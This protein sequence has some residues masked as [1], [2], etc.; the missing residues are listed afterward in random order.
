MIGRL[1]SLSEHQFDI[2]IIGCGPAALSAAVN[3]KNKNRDIVVLGSELCSPPMH[4]APMINNYLGFPSITGEELRQSFLGHA[5]LMGVNIIKSKAENVFPDENGY[6]VMSGEEMLRAKTVI[7]CI[8]TPYRQTLKNEADF[9]GKGLGYCATCD[10]PLYKGKDVAIVGYSAEAE[11]EANYLAEICNKVYYLPLYKEDP[12]V[13]SEVEVIRERPV[14]VEGDTTVKTLTTKTQQ[15][16]VHG[17]FVVGAEIA[18]DRLV[19]GLELA[20]NF[21]KVNS[22][23]ET[24]LPGIFAAGDC[25]GP[26]YQL[27]KAAGQGQIAGLNAT[28]LVLK[29]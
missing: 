13:R 7:L 22:Q 12:Q 4:K 2:A 21:I 14:S 5:S 6:I 28:K 25:T 26:P 11:P 27:S 9:L 18:P 3:A 29:M 1:I 15:L 10:G 19:P 8:G 24:N 23:M 20:E 17:V 16:T